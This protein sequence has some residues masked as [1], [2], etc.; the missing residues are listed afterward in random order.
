MKNDKHGQ[1][2]PSLWDEPP[3]Q[4][5][6]KPS[7]RRRVAPSS[8]QPVTPAHA[9]NDSTGERLWTAADLAEYLGVPVKTIYAWRAKGLGP[10]GF[11]LGKHLRWHRRAVVDWTLTLERDQ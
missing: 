9:A 6:P 8:P 11:R 1:N 4:S 10:K 5:P 3:P 7:P 2:Q